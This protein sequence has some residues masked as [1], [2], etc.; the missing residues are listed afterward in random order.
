MDGYRRY[1]SK[2]GNTDSALGEILLKISQAVSTT[3]NL[4]DLFRTIHAILKNIVDAANF[5]IGLIDTPGDRL[6]FPYFQDERHDYLEIRNI[7]DPKTRSLSID[8]I[9]RGQP[10]FLT[11]EQII[12]SGTPVLGETPLVWI[13]IPLKIKGNVIGLMAVQEYS[14]PDLYQRSDIDMLVLVSEHVALAIERK[15]SEE[16]LLES[17]RKHRNII[18]SIEEGYYEIDLCYAISF[19]NDAL[20]DMTGRGR[21]ELM[22]ADIR[23]TISPGD[24]PV[25]SAAFDNVLDS[26]EAVKCIGCE[27]I[28]KDGTTLYSDISVSLMIDMNGEPVGFRGIFRDIT[29][30][31]KI[32]AELVRTRNFLQN[33]FDSTVD[34][35]I[36]TDLNGKVTFISSR[37]RAMLNMND[38][39][40]LGKRVYMIYEGGYEEAVFIM[41][42]LMTD[43]EL[44]N[45]EMKAVTKH[46]EFIDIHLSASLLKNEVGVVI[47]TLGIFRDISDKKRLEEQL[48]QAQKM[49][50]VATLAGG[51]AHNFNNILMA[52]QG[53]T[54]LMLFEMTES[55]PHQKML[56]NIE[57]QIENGARLTTRLIEY[58]RERKHTSGPIDLNRLIKETVYT[59]SSAKK[60]I[61]ISLNLDD[62]LLCIHANKGQI[63]QLLMNM[64]VNAVEAMPEGGRLHIETQNISG[65]E[66]SAL[67]TERLLKLDREHYILLK[68]RDTGIGMSPDVMNQIFEPFFTTKAMG[69]G[70][71]LGLSSVY[72]VVQSCGGL[73]NVE[74]Q[75]G[76]ETTFTIVLPAV[77]ETPPR[78]ASVDPK[79]PAGAPKTALMVDDEGM[80]L[81]VGGKMLKTMGYNVMLAGGGEE[82]L[83]I[84]KKHRS[85]IDLVILDMIMPGMSGADT[86]KALME[87]DKEVKVILTSG[88]DAEDRASAILGQG[89][90]VFIQKPFNL[91]LLSETIEKILT[92]KEA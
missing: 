85:D 71:G 58:A 33:I 47:G 35:I 46:N 67:K 63:E 79:K 53:Y 61:Q 57:K 62:S 29:E 40:I 22:G 48:R 26:G 39:D 91:E 86:Y 75:K 89:Q 65:K 56:Q 12:E 25:V 50:A 84:Y 83:D 4:D 59:F 38:K 66:A 21:P 44:K 41:K 10:V 43:G 49:K 64:F 68:I 78:Q 19:F 74:S 27:I 2:T 36:T 88:Y 34:S 17:E 42:T 90:A 5:F 31:K 81:D 77:E 73:I 52:I 11:R 82:A 9:R 13:G 37:A 69:K 72:G 3:R 18:E 14:E 28:R 30:K 7:S 15:M 76:R 92:M 87:I 54:S 6:I 70:T 20:C 23:S 24:I 45:H 55:H 80:I 8:V 32:A 16:A 1:T 60:E 51:I